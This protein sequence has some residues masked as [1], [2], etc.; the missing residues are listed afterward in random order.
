M[1][2]NFNFKS[3]IIINGKEYSSTG[4]MPD[5][6]REAYEKTKDSHSAALHP[7]G[8]AHVTTRIKF[9]DQEY[10]SLDAM[11]P[12]VRHTY[13]QVMTSLLEGKVA[14]DVIAKIQESGA[15]MGKR[16][17]EHRTIGGPQPMVFESAFSSSKRWLIAGLMLLLALAGF[18]YLL[19]AGGSK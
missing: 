8:L 14:P 7:D 13:D 15:T 19:S 6:I 17:I 5:D 16:T 11:P 9:N 3:K 12:D 1:K 2:I 4:E 18:F 10:E